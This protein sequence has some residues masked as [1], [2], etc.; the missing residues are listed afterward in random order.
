VDKSTLIVWV[1]V[2]AYLIGWQF[3]ARHM[4]RFLLER[5]RCHSESGSVSSRE[6]CLKWDPPN[7][8]RPDDRLELRSA[9]IAAAV[10]LVWPVA[11]F[12]LWLV[13][14]VRPAPE[15]RSVQKEIERLERELGMGHDA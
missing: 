2:T 10:A 14:T 9:A 3:T 7:C 15:P 11:L 1:S 4:G 13:H 12:P 5:G 8:W 6:Y